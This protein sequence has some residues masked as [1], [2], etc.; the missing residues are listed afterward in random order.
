[1]LID[2]KYAVSKM[3]SRYSVLLGD[4]ELQKQGSGVWYSVRIAIHCI[5]RALIWWR[6]GSS[7]ILS[8]AK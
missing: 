6:G 7:Q 4:I 3:M 2:E 5:A 1:M 8:A